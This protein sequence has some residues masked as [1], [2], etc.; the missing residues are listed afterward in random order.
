MREKLAVSE[1][2]AKA[3]AQLKVANIHDLT[4]MFST[5]RHSLI[6]CSCLYRIVGKIQTEVEN[7]GR[8]VEAGVNFPSE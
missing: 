6:F 8:R 2:T 4:F 3:E 7:V 5:K 1:R